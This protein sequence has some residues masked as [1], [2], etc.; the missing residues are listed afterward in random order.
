MEI[1]YVCDVDEQ[2]ICYE[3]IE[4]PKVTT[5]KD[6]LSTAKFTN[7]YDKIA[8]SEEWCKNNRR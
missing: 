5:Y 1:N 8:V 3:E 2:I 4:I 7:N 6:V